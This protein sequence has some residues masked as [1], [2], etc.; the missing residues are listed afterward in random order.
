MDG[1]IDTD[2]KSIKFILER[3]KLYI[4]PVA[5]MLICVI[6]FFQFI[7]PQFNMIFTAKENAREDL[8]KLDVLREDLR[9]LSGIDESSL[10]SQLEIL[11]H[12]LPSEK[13]F[14]GILNAINSSADGQG[15][16]LGSYSFAVGDLSGAQGTDKFP[17][18]QLSVPVNSDASTVNK[19]LGAISKSLPLSEISLVRIGGRASTVNLSFY[20]K[21]AF[22]A[23]IKNLRISPLS[24]KGLSLIEQLRSFK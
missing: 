6:L 5:I 8:L 12:A 15:A 4:A 13:D 24:S 10:D 9:M 16:I 20:Y 3:N 21:P 14:D 22:S 11:N 23:N 2:L 1:K 19:F 7:L 17:T 18:I